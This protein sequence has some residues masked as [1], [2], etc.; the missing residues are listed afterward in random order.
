[1]KAM[2]IAAFAFRFV[3]SSVYTSLLRRYRK[4]MLPSSRTGAKHP[5]LST[6]LTSSTCVRKAAGIIWLLHQIQAHVLGYIIMLRHVWMTSGGLQCQ[7]LF[8]Q[9]CDSE[10]RKAL[11]VSRP[12]LAM[13]S[14]LQ[15][16]QHIV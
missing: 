14:I 6:P 8:P 16:L 2:A 15:V 10:K 7:A 3:T 12:R 1:M 13:C 9:G 5:A 11:H 4:L